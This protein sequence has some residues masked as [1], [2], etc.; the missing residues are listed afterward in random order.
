MLTIVVCCYRYLRSS[1]SPFR[2]VFFVLSAFFFLL[3]AWVHVSQCFVCLL[4]FVLLLPLFFWTC[5]VVFAH[6]CVLITFLVTGYFAHFPFFLFFIAR[7]CLGV[8]MHVWGVPGHRLHP[9]NSPIRMICVTYVPSYVFFERF[10]S[11]QP[12]QN[13]ALHPYLC[14]CL[15]F[16]RLLR[17]YTSPCIHLNPSPPSQVPPYPFCACTHIYVFF[18]KIPGHTWLEIL[19]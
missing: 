4:W 19:H 3:G 5:Y 11:P 2:A 16:L 7:T 1:N 9:H 14:L 8:Y 6:F 18:G 17:V 15:C 10:C 13:Y 12:C